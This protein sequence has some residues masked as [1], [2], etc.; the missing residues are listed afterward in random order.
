[1]LNDV[2]VNIKDG[3]LGISNQVNEKTHVKIG[4]S[5]AE[6]NKAFIITQ[7]DVNSV[8]IKLGNTPL[9]DTV[10]DS[11]KAGASKIICVPTAGAVKGTKEAVTKTVT[12]EAT[13]TIDGDPL[14][15]YDIIFEVTKSGA[16]NAAAY[17]YSIDGGY[18]YSIEK[19]VPVNGS[20]L[21]DGTGLTLKFTEAVIKDNTFKVGDLYKFST[22]QPTMSNDEVL[23]AIAVLR[24][25]SLD[26]EFVHI[27]GGSDA[28]LWSALINEARTLSE[29]YF[30]PIFFVCESRNINQAE[31]LVDYV[32]SLIDSR[33][34]IQAIDSYRVQ[35]VTARV[36]SIAM[37]GRVREVN[38]AGIIT[39]LYS[40]AKL[41]QSIGEVRKFQ[42]NMITK[43]L[44]EGIE[45]YIDVLD[46]ANF[47][48]L[49][50]YIGLPG[51][52]VTNA[53][54]LAP[55]NSDYQYAETL[56]VANKAIKEV[57]KKALTFLHS[58]LDPTDTEGGV[59]AL[60]EFIQVPL[61][62]MIKSNDILS[63]EVIIPE[64]QDLISTSKLNAKVRVAPMPI[65]RDIEIEFSM[66]NP[67]T[68]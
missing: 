7:M 28:T 32:K 42:L 37:N 5:T 63:G 16:F 59:K 35:V 55:T 47:V 17:K 1:M 62:D 38:A 6:I 43:L 44:P 34:L 64:G 49:R 30:K 54:L 60:K 21:L 4:V 2:R 31:E 26:F 51:F 19:T 23:S 14:N 41:S 39:G 57:R 24:N 48:T 52:F 66:Y 33:K 10:M 22:K 58:Q 12:G 29:T 67:F 27:V 9:A 36:L 56:R 45:N 65:M 18:S 53:R 11:I 46:S 3:G 40:L 20:V 50:E 68:N 8:Y 13:L 15:S 61:E 25:N